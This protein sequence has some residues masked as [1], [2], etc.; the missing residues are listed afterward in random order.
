[1]RGVDISTSDAGGGNEQLALDKVYVSLDTKTSVE[2]PD[3]IGAGEE[4]ARVPQ[5]SVEKMQPLSALEAVIKNRCLVVLGDPGSG[6]S[7]FLNHLI[8]C[9]ALNGIGESSCQA[10]WCDSWPEEEADCVPIPVVLR[11]FAVQ[12]P[13]TQQDAKPTHLWDFITGHLQDAIQQSDGLQQ[14]A[15]N[16]LLLTVMVLVHTH[17]GRLPDA[18]HSL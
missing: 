17:K 14:L 3:E 1:M 12:L 8:L 4:D 13:P 11:D 7:T 6:K 18:S 10:G 5:D 16:P 15:P 2:L 9:L